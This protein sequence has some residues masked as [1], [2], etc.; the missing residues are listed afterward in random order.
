MASDFEAL[1]KSWNLVDFTTS[2]NKVICSFDMKQFSRRI[3]RRMRHATKIKLFHGDECQLVCDTKK[4]ELTLAIKDKRVK[5]VLDEFTHVKKEDKD[6]LLSAI[7]RAV[8]QYL[9]LYYP[10]LIN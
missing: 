10:A 3:Q 9:E 1:C 7:G 5:V 2:G 6:H 4:E 8:D